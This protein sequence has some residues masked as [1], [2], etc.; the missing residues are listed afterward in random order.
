M[1]TASIVILF[2]IVTGCDSGQ[3]DANIVYI[4][5]IGWFHIF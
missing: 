5:I 4:G 2:F 3:N 1:T